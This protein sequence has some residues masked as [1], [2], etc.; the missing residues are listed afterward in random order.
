[1][2]VI[3]YFLRKY[4]LLSKNICDK[5]KFPISPQEKKKK[6]GLNFPETLLGGGRGYSQ[7]CIFYCR[8]RGCLFND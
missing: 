5:S 4:K 3:L 1:M 6:T 2:F 8:H 7:G